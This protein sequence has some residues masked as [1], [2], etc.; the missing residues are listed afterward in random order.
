MEHEMSLDPGSR[1]A[2]IGFFLRSAGLGLGVAALL[3]IRIVP[4]GSVLG[5]SSALCTIAALFATARAA[6]R[7][8]LLARGSLNAWD[9]AATF[10]GGFF[11]IHALQRLYGWETNTP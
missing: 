3:A 7:K 4:W 11:V 6:R 2:L 1:P 5:L 10:W 8:E 9:E